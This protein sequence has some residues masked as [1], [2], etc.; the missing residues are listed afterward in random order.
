MTQQQRAH[1]VVLV[2]MSSVYIQALKMLYHLLVYA[3]KLVY[4]L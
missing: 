3:C 1:F 4:L 2:F